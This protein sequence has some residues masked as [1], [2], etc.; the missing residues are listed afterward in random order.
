MKTTNKPNANCA[1]QI[2]LKWW[3]IRVDM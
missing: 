3:T 2:N 1:T